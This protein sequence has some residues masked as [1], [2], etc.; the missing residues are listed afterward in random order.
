MSDAFYIDQ[1]FVSDGHSASDQRSSWFHVF[2]LSNVRAFLAINCKTQ[3]MRIIVRKQATHTASLELLQLTS[4]A[5]N[6][7]ISELQL[8]YII[9]YWVE[10]Y[11]VHHQSST[12][13]V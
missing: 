6:I 11:T 5:S 7:I 10:K 12:A 2:W 4:I 8:M 9:V 1:R 13:D 3:M